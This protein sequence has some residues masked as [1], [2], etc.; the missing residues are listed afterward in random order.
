[1]I[2]RAISVNALF[3]NANKP[4]EKVLSKEKLLIFSSSEFL[5]SLGWLS[6]E[7]LKIPE[8]HCQNEYCNIKGS[9]VIMD[10]DDKTLL[11]SNPHPALLRHL[12]TQ[13]RSCATFFSFSFWT[14]GLFPWN[15]ATN[16]TDRPR[17]KS[18]SWALPRAKTGIR[19]R[20][21]RFTISWTNPVKRCSRSSLFSWMWVP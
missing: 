9:T 20:P 13:L 18:N 7:P 5:L 12:C 15:I 1:M 17:I 6:A 2:S 14:W 21:P 3:E 4:F 11:Q 16:I 10:D 8:T 19:Q